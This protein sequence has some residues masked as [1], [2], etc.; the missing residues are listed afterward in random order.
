MSTQPT[1]NKYKSWAS[2]EDSDN[3][4]DE[5]NRVFLRLNKVSFEF[6]KS[7]T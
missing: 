4:E 3:D 1:L 2:Y 6:S 7:S 5:H